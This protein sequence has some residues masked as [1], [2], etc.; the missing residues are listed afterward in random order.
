[1][2][3]PQP[4]LVNFIQTDFI[5]LF[6][7][8]LVPVSLCFAVW[9]ALKLPVFSLGGVQKAQFLEQLTPQVSIVFLGIAAMGSALA[10]VVLAVRLRA[11]RKAFRGLLVP[12]R[13]TRITKFKDRAYLHFQYQHDSHKFTTWRFVHQTAAVKALREDQEVQ[14]AFD[15]K[16]P[17]SAWVAEL[18]L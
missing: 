17:Q 7:S 4:R 1:M 2:S 5:S 6:L 18:F 10:A 11:A 14:V 12:G 16:H 3:A 15:P 8:L 13:V 9:A